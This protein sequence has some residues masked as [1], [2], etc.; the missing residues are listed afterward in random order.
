MD[1]E[2]IKLGNRINKAARFYAAVQSC[3][4]S[5]G[6]ITE[7]FGDQVLCNLLT[8]Q[9]AIVTDSFL[10]LDPMEDVLTMEFLATMP[11]A[12]EWLAHVRNSETGVPMLVE[13]AA[14]MKTLGINPAATN[15]KPA[16]E[17]AS[18]HAAARMLNRRPF[19]RFC[20]IPIGS[21]FQG[22]SPDVRW[23]KVSDTHGKF[24]GKHLALTT[25]GSYRLNANIEVA[26]I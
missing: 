22:E 16:R 11:D 12:C 6:K 17:H 8:L 9:N 20:E 21:M 15:W 3:V 1:K 18:M 24:V 13:Q 19:K 26:C 5:L 23:V 7:S 4:D 10:D 2:V 14:A 25:G